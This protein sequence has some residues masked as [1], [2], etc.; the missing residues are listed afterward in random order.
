MKVVAQAASHSNPG[1]GARIV[2]AE[3]PAC[4][5]TRRKGGGSWSVKVERGE[6]W[7]DFNVKDLAGHTHTHTH[8]SLGTVMRTEGSHWRRVTGTDLC[9]VV[10]GAACNKQDVGDGSCIR[11]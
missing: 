11:D 5:K 1:G 6:Q 10:I 4:A 7:I 2:K 8:R 3:R 9:L